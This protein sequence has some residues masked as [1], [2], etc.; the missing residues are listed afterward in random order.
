MAGPVE[1]HD[2]TGQRDD[3]GFRGGLYVTVVCLPT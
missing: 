2:D 3:K 1:M